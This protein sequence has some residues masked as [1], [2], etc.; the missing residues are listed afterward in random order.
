MRTSLAALLFLLCALPAPAAEID[1]ATTDAVLAL[2]TRGYA[3]P[4][5]AEIRNLHV[6]RAKNGRGYCGEVTIEGAKG[7]FTVFHAIL[8]DDGS[9]SILRLSD[10]ID[11]PMEPNSIAVFTLLK[12]F[13][14]TE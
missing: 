11:R 12:N 1:E 2:A 6:S 8:T 5:H 3:D 7:A 14:C 13:G 4:A 10:Y 9:S